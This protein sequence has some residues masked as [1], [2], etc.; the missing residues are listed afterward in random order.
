L[1]GKFEKKAPTNKNRKKTPLPKDDKRTTRVKKASSTVGEG[2][3]WEDP[4][5][6]SRK[7]EG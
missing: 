4:R 2:K 7:K 1:R 6:G 3:P 5:W